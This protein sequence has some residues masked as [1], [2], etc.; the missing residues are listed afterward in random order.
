M[1]PQTHVGPLVGVARPDESRWIEAGPTALCFDPSTPYEVWH[2]LTRRLIEVG[3]RI[4]WWIA[5]AL[6]FGEAAY[7]ERYAQ[8]LETDAYT[9]DSLRNLAW[10]SRSVAP[11]RR[12]DTVPFSHHAEVAALEPDEQDM[13]L[14]QCEEEGINRHELRE[15]V[16]QY[17][18]GRARELALAAPAPPDVL[19]PADVRV[20]VADARCLPL[21]DGTVDLTVASPPYALDVAYEGGDVAPDAWPSFMRAWLEEAYRVTAEGGRLAVNVPVDTTKRGY[22]PTYAQAVDDAIDA[23]W[24]Y[25]STIVW[26][27]E[28][29]SKSTARGSVDSPQAVRV[30]APVEMV[31]VFSKGP[32]RRDPTGRTW[33]LAHDE[34]VEW[35]NGL[36]RFPGESAPWEGFEGAVPLELPRRLIK[37]LSFHDD[38]VLDPFVGSGTTAVAAVRLGRRFVGFDIGP[39][40]V[41]SAK[42][43]LALVSGR[44]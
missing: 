11:S 41:D 21:E 12:R 31:A 37:L 14:A 29:V 19:L 1:E 30:V 23:G 15:R 18:R 7:G 27:E 20:E 43:R 40:Q 39:S 25:Q 8:V 34:W 44:P 22:R 35:T 16:Q 17:R 33:D 3:R 36:W 5:D 32:W 26:D 9:Y 4:Q 13:F 10:V 2:D 24:A 42:R 38:L 6:A 28:N